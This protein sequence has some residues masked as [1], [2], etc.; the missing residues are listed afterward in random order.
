MAAEAGLE[1]KAPEVLA[2]THLALSMAEFARDAGLFEPFHSRLFQAYFQEGQNISEPA[3]LLT[4]AREAGL[5]GPDLEKELT[6]ESYE[7]RLA[8]V[9]QEATELEI[10][11]V[12]TF[13][14]KGMRVV[15]AQPY[16][17]IAEMVERAGAR[18]RA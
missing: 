17:L 9:R 11:G 2:N 5:T 3:V 7:A 18:R 4:A 16:E 13:L 15:G 12:P 8:R 14:I 6:A 1:L 10:E